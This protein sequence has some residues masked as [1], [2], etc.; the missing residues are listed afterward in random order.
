[1]YVGGIDGG[2]SNHNCL[3]VCWIRLW[4]YTRVCMRVYIHTDTDTTQHTG[5]LQPMLSSFSDEDLFPAAELMADIGRHDS[6]FMEDV[7][8]KRVQIVGIKK[9]IKHEKF[10]PDTF[11]NDIA[12]IQLNGTVEFNEHIQPICISRHSP[13]KRQKCV[14]AGWGV[15]EGRARSPAACCHLVC[16]SKL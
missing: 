10:D 11:K 4:A 12:L 14:I 16:W 3:C 1:M 6:G 5:T 7:P 2:E 13:I 15:T 8:P 9:F